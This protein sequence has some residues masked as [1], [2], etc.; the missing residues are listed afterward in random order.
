MQK[1]L[2][3]QILG[4]RVMAQVQRKP[5][6]ETNK[7]GPV[8]SCSTSQSALHNQKRGRPLRHPLRLGAPGRTRLGGRGAGSG[9]VADEL[10][11]MPAWVPARPAAPG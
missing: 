8:K 11:L 2:V 10:A 4:F 5:D 1:Q 6:P 7:L 9:R 3:P